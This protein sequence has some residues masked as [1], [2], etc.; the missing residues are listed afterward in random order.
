MLR[1]CVPGSADKAA[2][3]TN[4]PAIAISHGQHGATVDIEPIRFRVFLEF[5]TSSD[6][7]IQVLECIRDAY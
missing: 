1:C 4:R 5:D 7:I 6:L 2:M 3:H